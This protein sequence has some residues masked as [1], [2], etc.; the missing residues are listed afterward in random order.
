MRACHIPVY[1]VE[2]AQGGRVNTG[3]DSA[4]SSVDVERI[5]IKQA[6]LNKHRQS[7]FCA[8][9]AYSPRGIACFFLRGFPCAGLK[10]GELGKF[11]QFAQRDSAIP[12]HEHK[13]GLKILPLAAVVKD[14]RFDD[15]MLV[16]AELSGRVPRDP[17]EAKN[18]VYPQCI[19]SGCT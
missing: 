17:P 9:G 14:Q 13:K 10:V 11:L 16:K 2:Q 5:Q 4:F 8:K 6:F 18:I 3:Y 12:V 7:I 15:S 19:F 1:S